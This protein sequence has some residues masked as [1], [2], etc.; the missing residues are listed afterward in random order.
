M[1]NIYDFEVSYSLVKRYVIFVFKRF[2]GEYIVT[3]RENIP[4]EGP[5]IF[6]ANHLNALMDALAVI[7]VLPHEMPIVYLGRADL[8][9]N[10]SFAKILQF[11]KI[12]PAFRMRDGVENLEKNHGIFESCVDVLDH[13][14]VLGIMPEGNQGPYRKLRPLVKGIF[15][16][17]FSAQQKY[18]IQPG[19][20]IVPI[21]IDMGD[22]EKYGEHLIINIGKPID[23]SDY[24]AGYNESQANATNQI[25]DRLHDELSKLTFNLATEKHYESFETATKVADSS[26]NERQNKRVKLYHR[27][28]V[29]QKVAKRLVTMEKEEPEKT[30]RLDILC[31][32][33]KENLKKLNI[34]SWVMGG[35]MMKTHSLILTSLFFLITFPLFSVGFI[36][37]I[38]PFFSPEAIRRA[39]KIEY[40]GGLSS[41]RFG[42]S[43]ITFPVFYLLQGLLICGLIFSS[44]WYII[45]VI[46]FQYI[47]GVTA[48]QWYQGLRKLQTRFRFR[49]LEREKS[50][51]FIQTRFLFDQINKTVQL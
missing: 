36:L 18:G 23:V 31:R 7:S 16:I 49:S 20:K 22:F 9:K 4:K 35:K 29:R 32:E 51:D 11:S 33:Y 40:P 3:G 5:V 50:Q 42:I 48:F 19:V 28:I 38:F 39:L 27:F 21:G 2:Y 41:V 24:M 30:E 44:W 1:S 47:L 43:L 46:P 10:K 15:R 17:A 45:L 13:N 37:N 8:F 14:K 25:R 12:L 34:D 6:A 26:I